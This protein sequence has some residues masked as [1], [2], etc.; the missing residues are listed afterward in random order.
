MKE[1]NLLLTGIILIL[2]FVLWTF[3]ILCVDVQPIG[4]NGTKIGFATLNNWFHELT[5]V[6]MTCYYITDWLGLIPIFCCMFFGIVGFIQMIK[7]GSLLKVDP[8]I[9]ALG[10]YY[11]IVILGYL[12]FEMIPINYRPILINGIVETS[13]PSSTTLL[14]LSVIPTVIFQV[15]RRV[16]SVFIRKTATAIF[17]SFSLFMT[18]GRTAAGVHWL[19]DIIGSIILS[20]GLYL[21]YHSVVLWIDKKQSQ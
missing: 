5:D 6:N 10:S 8:D 13:Y 4:P 1:K 9:V 20:S 18:I 15:W 17:V 14:T 2:V 7:R 21:I 12:L 3:L 19:T 11:I 16:K